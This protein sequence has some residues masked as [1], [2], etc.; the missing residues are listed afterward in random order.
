MI[1]KKKRSST[2]SWFKKKQHSTEAAGSELCLCLKPKNCRGCEICPDCDKKIKKSH[3][4]KH[5][6]H[7]L[8]ETIID[9]YEICHNAKHDNVTSFSTCHN[10]SLCLYCNKNIIDLKYSEHLE[11]HQKEAK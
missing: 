7:H 2:M 9:R 5:L 3:L 1:F 11:R 8:E 6:G 4:T 10:C